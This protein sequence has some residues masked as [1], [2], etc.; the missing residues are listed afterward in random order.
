MQGYPGAR[1]WPCRRL[2]L[3][4]QLSL[5][6]RL[7]PRQAGGG[8][9]VFLVESLLSALQGKL[10]TPGL[11]RAARTLSALHSQQGQDCAN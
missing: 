10:L 3:V 9:Q 8:Q 11:G 1:G 6:G 4:A 5:G 7:E 2:I